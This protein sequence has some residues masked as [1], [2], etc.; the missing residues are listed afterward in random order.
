MQQPLLRARPERTAWFVVWTAFAVFC[1][2][3]VCVPLA[4][5]Y[6]L[7]YSTAAHPAT[8]QTLEG[9]AVIDSPA[10]GSES[11]VTQDNTETCSEGAVISLDDKSRAVLHFFEGTSVYLLPGSRVSLER[12]RGPRFSLGVTPNTIALRMVGGRVKIVTAGPA[13][14]TDLDFALHIPRLN[15]DV[16]I[17]GDGVYGVELGSAG[18]DIFSNRGSAVVV[19]GGKSVRLLASERTTVRPDA[20]PMAPIADARELIVNS[21]F[22][23]SLEPSWKV[24]NVQGGDEGD[25]PGMAVRMLDEGSPAVRFFRTGGQRNHCE[26]VIEQSINRDLPDPASS[27]RVRAYIK[28]INQSLSGG[29]YMGS[30]FPLVIRLKYRDIYGSENEW[31]RGF[32]YQN[33]DN[34][35]TGGFEVSPKD[36]WFLFESDNLLDSVKPKPF[37]IVSVRVY[38]SGWDYESMIRWISLAVK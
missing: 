16:S 31:V 29:G 2:L 21:D 22:R 15:A 27:L 4:A 23:E 25:V 33:P 14:G 5:R 10:T 19:A 20:Q 13:G 32:Y 9:T 12:S 11:A 26:T 37:R 36:S 34:N 35:P 18:A 30:E 8:L 7:L 6:I 17:K 38:A 28:L 1:L 24:F 3:V